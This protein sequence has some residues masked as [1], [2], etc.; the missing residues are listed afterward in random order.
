[1]EQRIPHSSD[2]KATARRQARAARQS[3]DDQTRVQASADICHRVSQHPCFQQATHIAGYLP[4]KY[5]VDLR[6]LLSLAITQHKKVWIPRVIDRNMTFAAYHPDHPLTRSAVGTQQPS[7]D[8]QTQDARGIDLALLPLLAFTRS[9][10]RLG[11]GGGY[12]D[13]AFSFM[14]QEPA[15][16]GPQLTGTAFAIQE[17]DTLPRDSWDVPLQHIVTQRGWTTCR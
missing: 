1:M 11:L 9:G 14:L 10:I 5:E 16:A 12:Y 6:P 4:L 3:L 17:T 8:A 13:R 15:S 7:E 2:K